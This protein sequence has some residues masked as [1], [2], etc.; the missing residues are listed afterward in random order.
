[1]QIHWLQQLR[2]L[3]QPL[4]HEQPLPSAENYDGYIQLE[5]G[6]GMIT[7][8]RDE[9]REA[10]AA[11]KGDANLKRTVTLVTGKLAGPILEELTGEMKEKFPNVKI[12]VRV[13]RNDF[14][15]ERI[16]VAGLL[17]GQD[18]IAQ[19]KDED[20]GD[21]ILLPCNVLRMGEDVFLDD[22]TLTELKRTLQVQADIVKSSGQDLLNAVLGRRQNE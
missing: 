19:L 22:I 10:L 18:I 5:N 20:L 4:L 9:F 3:F 17:T 6:V 16:T 7:L 11:E 8:L 13:I 21:E 12:R 1:V 15:G 2:I 14:F